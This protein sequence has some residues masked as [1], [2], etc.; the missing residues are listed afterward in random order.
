MEI[1]KI[2]IAFLFIG[3]FVYPVTHNNYSS[4]DSLN[5]TSIYNNE[6]DFNEGWE[7]GFCEGWKDEK[8]NYAICPIT[9]LPPL[10]KIDESRNSWRD[11]YNRGFK[12]GICKARGGRCTK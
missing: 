1:K 3:S 2:L 6:S 7:E 9:P 12:Y 8:G 5:I 10:P 4:K 11:G